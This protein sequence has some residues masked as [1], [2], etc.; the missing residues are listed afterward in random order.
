MWHD[1]TQ[2]VSS[3]FIAMFGALE[4]EGLLDPLNEVDI[5]C[6]HYVAIP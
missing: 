2:C 4:A 3:F 6:L 5:F 1:I